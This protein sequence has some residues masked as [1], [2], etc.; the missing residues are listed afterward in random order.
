MTAV[1]KIS[2]TGNFWSYRNLKNKAVN[3]AL[4]ISGNNKEL[5]TVSNPKTINAVEWIGKNLSSAEN[6]LILGASALMTQ[7]FIDASNK[8]VDDETRRYS[9][10]R[11]VAKILACTT[12]GYFIRKGCIKSIDA[13]TKLPSEITPDMKFKKIRSCLLPTVKYTKDGLAQHK[14]T[15][16]TLLA[17]GVMLFT[18]FLI[19]AP[20]TKWLT[21]VFTGQKGASNAQSK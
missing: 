11:T 18:N 19:D 20:L 21:N 9:I 17:L 12:T 13:F 15:L 16:G 8:S 6:R 2:S 1:S 4:K 3:V 7:P 10:C 5:P 14:N